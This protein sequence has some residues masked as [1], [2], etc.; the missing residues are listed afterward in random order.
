MK[1]K[2]GKRH[3]IY[4]WRTEDD[5]IYQGKNP[6][7][8]YNK[9]YDYM[10]LAGLSIHQMRIC[11]P[12][13]DDQR[14]G[15]W[16]YHVIEPETWSKVVQRVSGANSGSMYIQRTGNINGYRKISK[17]TGHTWQSFCELI[18]Q[19][20]PPKSK[21]HYE[22]MIGKYVQQWRGRVYTEGIPDEA[23]IMIEKKKDVPSWRKIC[24]CLLRN[25]FWLRGLDYSQQRS[26]AYKKIIEM[27][28]RKNKIDTNQITIGEETDG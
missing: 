18:L 23:D 2:K 14:R 3:D 15:L 26:E 20:M 21:E 13:G 16:L 24:K 11:Q 8:P 25:D 1:I 28:D 4:D 5:W 12:Y 19:S 22:T 27:F 7:K 9:I 6:H 10:Y 17:P